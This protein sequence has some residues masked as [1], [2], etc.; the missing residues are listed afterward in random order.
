MKKGLGLIVAVVLMLVFVGSKAYA[1]ESPGNQQNAG[2]KGGFFVKNDD[3]SFNLKIGGRVQSSFAYQKA[4]PAASKLTFML[5][6]AQASFDAKIADIVTASMVLKH[7]VQSVPGATQNTIF[8]TVNIAGVELGVEVIPEKLT[9]TAGMVGLPL[10]LMTSTSS[11]WYLLCNPPVT[12]TQD[13][14]AEEITA[15]RPSFSAPDGIG[16]RLSGGFWKWYYEAAIV[17]GAA[18]STGVESNYELSTNKKF[19]Y[20][21]R[22][23]IN[24]LGDGYQGS[25]T[26]FAHS[27]TPQLTVNVGTNYQT[28]RTD[29]NTGADVK[30]LWTNTLGANFRWKGFALTT[31]GYYRKTVI[32]N[33]GTAVWARPKLTDVGYYA[34]LGYYFIPKKFEVG[35]LAGQIIRQGPNNDSW[36]FG[37]GL[38]YYVFNNNLKLQ[39]SYTLTTSFNDVTDIQTKKAHNVQLMA[40][41]KF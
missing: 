11:S 41:A 24:I 8:Q 21:L 20:G 37:G 31:E 3:D 35:A 9:I 16:L 30:Y 12:S 2:Y 19:S 4:S 38:N 1:E 34:T 14:G 39:L 15:L 13:D 27:E 40:S 28:K 26:D 25:Q 36:Q 22:T 7:A 23:G 18:A 17:N 32:N 33:V 6:R 5:N 10:D 29:P